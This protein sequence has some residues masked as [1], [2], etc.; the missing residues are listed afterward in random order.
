M[1]NTPTFKLKK[2][3]TNILEKARRIMGITRDQYAFCS[4][5]QYRCADPRQRI[6]GW[7]CD[8][9]E[10]IGDF[11]GI[12][13]VG[14]HK[15]A[16]A[17][18][19]SGLIM[20]SKN[21]H[22]RVTETWIDIE[23]DCKQSLQK[24]GEEN[25]NKV[26]I[27]RKQSLQIE[28]EKRK[29]SLHAPY[30]IDNKELEEGE[31]STPSPETSNLKAE[32]TKSEEVAPGRCKH[33]FNP[34]FCGHCE[35]ERIAAEAQNAPSKKVA[36]KKVSPG[37]GCGVCESCGG[38]GYDPYPNH[39]TTHAICQ[40]C[41]GLGFDLEKVEAAGRAENNEVWAKI[42]P[43]NIV[44]DINPSD[45]NIRTVTG[46]HVSE[47]VVK[48]ATFPQQLPP[49]PRVQTTIEAEQMIANWITGEGIETVKSR[50]NIA[51][52]RFDVEQS[53]AIAAHYCS[54]YTKNPANKERLLKDPITHFS[55]GL[56]S[57][58]KNEQAF[59]RTNAPTNG[60]AT[61]GQQP[62]TYTAPKS[63]F[64]SSEL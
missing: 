38:S 30:S 22:Y 12:S 45:P 7:C 20:I 11:V 56:F 6:A 15:M 44:T 49:S 8:L 24:D 39:S 64:K 21:S 53:A 5:I 51:M 36:P 60:G 28:R 54:V 52:Q 62:A 26:Y 35:A 3:G 17:M 55:D 32:K 33:D 4:Y 58:L 34:D 29:Q 37:E 23:S 14:V 63:I 43:T 50:Y 57:Y 13:R 46:L 9:K 61:R 10:E 47:P 48:T 42:A 31:E 41:N 1:S 25:V 18:E 59:T 16:R 19:A 2:Q 40:E 27:G